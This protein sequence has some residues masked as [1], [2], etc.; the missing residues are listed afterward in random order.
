MKTLLFEI[1][2]ED[3]V[4]LTAF[5]LVC[6]L[7]FLLLSF[8]RKKIL[9]DIAYIKTQE[10][11]VDV[12][13]VLMNKTGVALSR[14]IKFAVG[15]ITTSIVFLEL[16]NRFPKVPLLLLIGICTSLLTIYF[17]V[18]PLIHASLYLKGAVQKDI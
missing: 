1:Y 16:G 18:N 15:G 7:I 13:S 9:S 11:P 8:Q 2:V 17:V 5:L 14:A 4:L 3:I 10:D 6:L 12:L